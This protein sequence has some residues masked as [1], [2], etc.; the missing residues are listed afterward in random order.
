[1]TAIAKRRLHVSC[2]RRWR[3]FA[4]AQQGVTVVEFALVAPLFIF[5]VCTVFDQGLTLLTQKVMDN[6][7]LDATRIIRTNHTAGS[8][9]AFR[10]R[11]CIDMHGSVPCGLLQYYVQSGDSF[12]TMNAGVVTNPA[13]NLR[14]NGTFNPGSPGQDVIVQVAYKR[15]TLVPLIIPVRSGPNIVIAATNLLVSTVAFQNEPQ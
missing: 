10:S 7:V 13:G 11:L 9:A 15:P 6:A 3:Q 4:R 8:V 14:F 2:L 5:L 1:M 12:S